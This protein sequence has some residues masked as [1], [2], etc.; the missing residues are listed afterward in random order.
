MA[1]ILE[2]VSMVSYILA[3]AFLIISVFLWFHFRILEV[4]GDL[5]GRTAKKSITKIRET[6]E[7]NGAKFNKAKSDFNKAAVYRNNEKEKTKENNLDTGLLYENKETD[8]S[9]QTG[10]LTDETVEIADTKETSQL[11]K[12]QMGTDNRQR[13]IIEEMDFELIE[14]LIFTHTNEVIV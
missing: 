5:S 3:V 8:V 7:R 9:A 6:N 11:G 10:L 13:D 1:N 4:I 14:E 2:I 12:I